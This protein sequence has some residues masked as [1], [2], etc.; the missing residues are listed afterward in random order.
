MCI[1]IGLIY[2]KIKDGALPVR[3]LSHHAIGLTP[4]SVSRALVC[5]KGCEPKNPRCA[6]SGLGCGAVKTGWEPNRE[7]N[8][9]ACRPHKIATKRDRKSVVQGKRNIKGAWRNAKKKIERL[10]RKTGLKQ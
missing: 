5:E 6:E 2:R 4:R 9:C 3:R 7:P 1:P 8:C 10:K